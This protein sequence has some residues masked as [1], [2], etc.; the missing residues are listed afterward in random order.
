MPVTPVCGRQGLAGMW[1][2]SRRSTFD[3]DVI[4]GH[5]KF[6]SLSSL[7]SLL[8]SH[9]HSLAL[10]V[11]FACIAP[12]R[13]VADV[14]S[15]ASLLLFFWCPSCASIVA[16]VD[17]PFQS[18]YD[19][20]FPGRVGYSA[21]GYQAFTPQYMGGLHPRAKQTIGRRLALAASAVYL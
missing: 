16:Q 9:T 20:P 17:Q 8:S 21:N 10:P 19:T 13:G 5:S 3:S 18:S 15:V 7:F 14:L 1:A 6:H 4:L 12:V 2:R 11:V